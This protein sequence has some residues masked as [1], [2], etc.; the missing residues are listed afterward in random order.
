[1]GKIINQIKKI[2][3]FI[4]I[5]VLPCYII[6][7]LVRGKSMITEVTSN[8]TLLSAVVFSLIVIAIIIIFLFKDIIKVIN[9]LIKVITSFFIGNYQIL[10]ALE[11]IKKPIHTCIE[12]NI[13]VFASRFL[14]MDKIKRNNG[15]VRI[16]FSHRGNQHDKAEAAKKSSSI[17]LILEESNLA[18]KCWSVAVNCLGIENVSLSCSCE[19]KYTYEQYKNKNEIPKHLHDNLIL[20]GSSKTNVITRI[21]LDKAK[22]EFD[23]ICIFKEEHSTGD[24]YIYYPNKHKHL[25]PD[26]D[27]KPR[28]DYALITRIRNPFEKEKFVFIFAGCKA[29]G[30]FALEYFFLNNNV[31]EQIYKKYYAQ[32]TLQII[33]KVKYNYREPIPEFISINDFIE[34]EIEYPKDF[35]EDS[36]IKLGKELVDKLQKQYL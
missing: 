14:F 10:K 2:V 5:I 6:I 33:L 19:E 24:S 22:Q 17:P 21:I 12:N 35:I 20:F 28:L 9:K 16:Y 31:L 23:S 29:G 13:S 26:N 32:E 7:L 4:P 15:T 30:A 18:M 3:T 36:R 1:M 34:F 25:K 27:Q 8:F 11:E